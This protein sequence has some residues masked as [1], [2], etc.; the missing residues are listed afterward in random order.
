MKTSAFRSEIKARD[1]RNACQH[2][3]NWLYLKADDLT[4]VDWRQ[5]E[6]MIEATDRLRETLADVRSARLERARL[7]DGEE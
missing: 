2:L 6:T 7:L 5:I 1:F 3:R 4:A